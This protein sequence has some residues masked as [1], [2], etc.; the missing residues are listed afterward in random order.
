MIHL[1]GNATHKKL[2]TIPVHIAIECN[3][4]VVFSN[5]RNIVMFKPNA[6]FIKSIGLKRTKKKDHGW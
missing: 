5:T 2:A 1:T 4:P 6:F 3:Y